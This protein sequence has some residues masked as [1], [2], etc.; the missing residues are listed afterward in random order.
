MLPEVPNVPCGVERT[1]WSPYF[2]HGNSVPNVPCGVERKLSKISTPKI[3]MF[4][5]Y[6]VELKDAKNEEV[7]RQTQAEFLMYRVELKALKAG[8]GSPAIILFLMY[9]VELKVG[10]KCSTPQRLPRRFLMYRV[11]LKDWRTFFDKKPLRVPNVPC[12]VER[13]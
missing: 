5:M 8:S 9:R 4:L 7:I 11:E 6:R 13:G 1:A 2:L 3:N 10:R 12:G